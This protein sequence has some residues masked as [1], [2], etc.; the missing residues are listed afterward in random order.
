MSSS[1]KGIKPILAKTATGLPFINKYL[2]EKQQLF[3][4]SEKQAK[5]ITSLER[6]NQDLIDK[7]YP[8]G[9]KK[10]QVI[11]PLLQKEVINLKLPVDIKR[12]AKSKISLPLT[13]NWVVPPL[14][15]ASG[16]QA[17]IIRTIA[18]LES[19]GHTCRIYFYD[20]A[21][22]SNMES[23][24]QVMQE[25]PKIKAELF[26]NASTI[27]NS[28]IIFATDWISAYPVVNLKTN[29]RKYYYIQDFEPYFVPNS[30]FNVLA[31]STYKFGFRG[32]TLGKWLS[33]KLHEDYG[34]QCTPF[35]FGF[36]PK[37]YYFA[38]SAS[39][40]RPK[41]VAFYVRPR[42]ARRGFELGVMALSLF[43]KKHPEYQI[44]FF[45]ASTSNY[46]I[47][48]PYT[49]CGMLAP[50]AL[51][52]L[53]NNCQAGLVISL[54]N[55]S[56][57]PLEMIAAGCTPVSNR[58]DCT[59]NVFFAKHVAYAEPNPQDIFRALDKAVTNHSASSAR[60]ASKDI[61]VHSWDA[62]NKQIEKIILDDLS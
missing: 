58:A 48:F 21:E 60:Q 62:S 32:L 23:I 55:M 18:H 7:L 3:A 61:S 35:D 8:D 40:S 29:T 44:N 30:T 1:K 50:P 5:R 19:R 34:M 13:I 2:E 57:I 41:Q 9:Q 24:K 43:H 39:S 14:I 46:D 22:S 45:G 56:L 37:E 27:K 4:K 47:P 28:D 15:A 16:G 25:F 20:P 54:T 49:D 36:N 11:W 38:E 51:N 42:S 52:K 26:Y 17:D 12:S 33:Q 59:T 31:D 53:Y 10:A 6:Q